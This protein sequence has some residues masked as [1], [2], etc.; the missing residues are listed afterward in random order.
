MAIVRGAHETPE[1]GYVRGLIGKGRAEAGMVPKVRDCISW[2]VGQ[3][4]EEVRAQARFRGRLPIKR[5]WI[6]FLLL[7]ANGLGIWPELRLHSVMII[8]HLAFLMTGPRAHPRTW[9]VIGTNQRVAKNG[10]V[11]PEG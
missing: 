1:F 11:A 7:R 2:V 10:S 4:H 8:C 3:V 9:T 6:L 5:R